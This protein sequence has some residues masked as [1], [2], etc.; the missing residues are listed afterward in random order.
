MSH[1]HLSPIEKDLKAAR[2]WQPDGR[3]TARI[4]ERVVAFVHAHPIPAPRRWCL[5]KAWASVCSIVFVFGISSV[6]IAAE[7]ALPGD[8][9]Y[10]FKTNVNEALRGHLSFSEQRKAMWEAQRIQRRLEEV[11]QL[12]LHGGAVDDVVRERIEM[13]LESHVERLEERVQHLEQKK[14]HADVDRVVENLRKSTQ[15]RGAVLEELSKRSSS[16]QDTLK[17]RQDRRIKTRIERMTDR[18]GSSGD[19][20]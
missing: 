20:D 10:G 15:S 13:R 7:A 18:R 14:K 8:T 19:R 11:E 6:G 5:S 12:K 17:K 2:E 9:L 3:H 4:K 1:N 16:S